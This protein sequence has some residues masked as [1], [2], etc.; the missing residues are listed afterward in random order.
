M[1]KLVG[2][3]V[4]FAACAGSS[5]EL[6]TAHEAVYRAT[7]AVLFAGIK[8]ATAASYEI[9]NADESALSVQTGAKWY[10]PEGQADQTG[11][12]NLARLREDSINFSVVVKL[13]PM[14]DSAF[15]VNVDPTVLR[16]HGLSS[17]PENLKMNDPLTP[18]WVH[19]KVETLEVDVYNK[20]KQYAIPPAAN[21]A[22][23]GPPTGNRPMPG[24]PA[25]SQ[26]PPSTP[27][28]P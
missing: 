3:L 13:V 19:G 5:T 4:G 23:P 11:G 18:G 17:A 2:L 28:K 7:P 27:A 26:H 9:T 24:P 21:P 10:N 12:T 14:G 6:K 25:P 15:V 16:L 20:L 1:R 22:T 8:Q